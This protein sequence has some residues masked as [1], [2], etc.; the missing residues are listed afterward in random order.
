MDRDTALRAFQSKKNKTMAKTAK[1]KKWSEKVMTACYILL[2][3]LAED[4]SIER[5]ML[6]KGLLDSLVSH[7]STTSSVRLLN[8]I[9]NFIWKLAAMRENVTRLHEVRMLKYGHALN[10]KAATTNIIITEQMALVFYSHHM[11]I[12]SQ[13]RVVFALS[14]FL[15]A[16]A[17]MNGDTF[18]AEELT[19]SVL[20][21][22]EILFNDPC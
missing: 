1:L 14:M 19:T 8:T 10:R 20:K 13:M 3:N 12:C 9:V 17:T 18:P 11:I 22:K 6:K 16:T 4:L 5:K 7:L 2:T 21:V 15:P